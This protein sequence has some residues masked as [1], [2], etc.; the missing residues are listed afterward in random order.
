MEGEEL[1]H[2]ILQDK[3]NSMSDREYRDEEENGSAVE[4]KQFEVN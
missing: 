1:I 2:Q 3:G 4:N